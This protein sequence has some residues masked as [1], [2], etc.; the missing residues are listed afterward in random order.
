[1]YKY[2][3][4]LLFSTSVLSSQVESQTQI[5]SKNLDNTNTSSYHTHFPVIGDQATTVGHLKVN[6]D[7]MPGGQFGDSIVL[8]SLSLGLGERIEIGVLPWVYAV[9]DNDFFKYAVTFKYNVIKDKNYQIAFG[10]TQIKGQFKDS[11]FSSEEGSF[12]SYTSDYD[13]EV[14]NWFNYLFTSINMTPRDSTLNYGLTLKYSEVIQRTSVR[15]RI[16]NQYSDGTR[17]DLPINDQTK[18]HS[19][20]TTYTLDL[21]KQIKSHHWLGAAIGTGSKI[22]NINAEGDADKATAEASRVR[23]LIGFSYIYRKKL[24]FLTD[25]RIS[26]VYF[27]GL[28]PE[29][30]FST[31]F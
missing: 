26:V 29:F 17:F 9:E 31:S 30:G 8:N 6:F 23:H 16:T 15:G 7:R 20:L 4:L 3:F 14:N 25:P 24:S 21:N 10:G 27:E 13:F 22:S 5:E 28:G 19:Y 1:M 18:K 2:L 11:S 12:S